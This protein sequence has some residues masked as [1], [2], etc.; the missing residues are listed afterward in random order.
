MQTILLN[1]SAQ[2][3]NTVSVSLRDCHT[4]CSIKGNKFQQIN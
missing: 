3:V 1:I 4:E 2:A